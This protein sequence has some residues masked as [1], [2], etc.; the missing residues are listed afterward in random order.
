MGSGA[1]LYVVDLSSIYVLVLCGTFRYEL[2]AYIREGSSFG[3]Y[4]IATINNAIACMYIALI[5]VSI[6]II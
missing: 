6:L 1:E 4:R 3:A 2:M 5:I